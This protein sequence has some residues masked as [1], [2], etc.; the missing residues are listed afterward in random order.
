M[1]PLLEV[2]SHKRTQN[3]QNKTPFDTLAHEQT[4]EAAILSVSAVMGFILIEKVQQKSFF[5]L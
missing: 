3:V 5:F 4:V 2:L 1:L